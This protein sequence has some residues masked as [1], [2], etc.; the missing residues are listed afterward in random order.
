[1]GFSG[2]FVSAEGYID[3]PVLIREGKDEARKIAEFVVSDG[4][5]TYNAILEI[6]YIHELQQYLQFITR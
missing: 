5:S 3:L 1:M 4:S 2:E 6:P